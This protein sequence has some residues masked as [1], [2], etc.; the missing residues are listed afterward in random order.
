[1]LR[2]SYRIL[3]PGGRTAF[4]TIEPVAGL[5]EPAR[6]KAARIGPVSV[7]VPTSYPSLL[8]TARFREIVEHDVTE[9][10]RQ[11]QLDW[12]DAYTRREPELRKALGS[13]VFDERRKGRAKTVE[14]IDAGLL[15]RTFYSAVKA[16]DR[17]L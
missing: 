6:R 14:A 2:A 17:D 1:M 13:D 15:R 7:S 12:L 11:T 9:Q 10:F 16:V 4:F 8:N 3:K 5:D